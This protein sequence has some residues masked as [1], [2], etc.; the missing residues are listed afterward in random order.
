MSLQ[1]PAGFLLVGRAGGEPAGF[2]LVGRAGGGERQ[3][4]VR[5]GRQL[6]QFGRIDRN[7]QVER[8]YRALSA[9]VV[10]LI[11]RTPRRLRGWYPASRQPDRQQPL[12]VRVA[13]HREPSISDIYSLASRR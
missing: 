5:S 1:Q 4:A 6:A 7:S 3:Q 12:H 13:D 9:V 8:E 11:A 10:W 2:L